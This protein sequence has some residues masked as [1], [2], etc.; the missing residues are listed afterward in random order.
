[1]ED[2]QKQ[3]KSTSVFLSPVFSEPGQEEMENMN[4]L[5]T[6]SFMLYCNKRH[7]SVAL[8]GSCDR[9]EQAETKYQPSKEYVMYH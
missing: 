3:E 1:M 5:A 7:V 6:G 8:K 2:L 9:T 4:R